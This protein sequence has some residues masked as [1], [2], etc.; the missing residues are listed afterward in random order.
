MWGAI[1]VQQYIGKIR[2]LRK[3]NN[4]LGPKKRKTDFKKRTGNR[5][6]L[7]PQ[8]SQQFRRRRC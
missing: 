8:K 1:R 5:L 6:Y 3:I 7:T 2:K 4:H